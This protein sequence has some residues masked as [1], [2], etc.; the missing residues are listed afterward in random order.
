MCPQLRQKNWAIG[1]VAAS[2]CTLPCSST[3]A[4]ETISPPSH[5][6]IEQYGQSGTTPLSLKNRFAFS[7]CSSLSGICVA[8]FLGAL[9]HG[10]HLLR[11]PVAA[12]RLPAFLA[13]CGLCCI[14]QAP[15][16]SSSPA[17]L[18]DFTAAQRAAWS[19]SV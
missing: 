7:I 12:D 1:T 10:L 15:Q 3:T 8:P 9:L 2:G 18:P 6:C 5:P 16:A 11:P 19:R 17:I 4:A 14:P 13:L